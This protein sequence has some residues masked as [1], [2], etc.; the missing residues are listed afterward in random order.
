MK[1]QVM[2]RAWEKAGKQKIEKYIWEQQINNLPVTVIG[3]NVGK[4]EPGIEREPLNIGLINPLYFM[5]KKD[6]LKACK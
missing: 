3:N 1:I 4:V 6:L 5:G 2:W